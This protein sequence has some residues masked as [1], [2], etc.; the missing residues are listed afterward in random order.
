M[1]FLREICN[2]G[3]QIGQ[4]ARK[5]HVSHLVLPNRG[6]IYAASGSTK[7]KFRVPDLGHIELEGFMFD[8][9]KKMCLCTNDEDITR[10]WSTH[11]R[12]SR[13][14]QMPHMLGIQVV[15]PFNLRF[16]VQ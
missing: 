6:H 14:H 8:S 9:I 10:S 11:W 5:Q 2:P 12:T 4:K 1:V 13:A 7:A 16:G 3:H 15:V